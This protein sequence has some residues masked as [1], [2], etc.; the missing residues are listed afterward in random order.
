MIQ[1]NL[2]ILSDQIIHGKEKIRMT[3]LQILR[4]AKQRIVNE[5]VTD[6]VLAAPLADLMDALIEHVDMEQLCCDYGVRNCREV[7]RPAMRFADAVLAK[8]I[9]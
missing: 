6:D 7:G 9:A 8:E 1:H 3:D 4:A 5:A 2:G